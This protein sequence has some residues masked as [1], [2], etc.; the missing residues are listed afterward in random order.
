MQADAADATDDTAVDA[1][2]P[3]GASDATELRDTMQQPIDRARAVQ[4]EVDAGAAKQRADVDAQ[5]GY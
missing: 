5:T 4:S 1:T 3:A 2:Q